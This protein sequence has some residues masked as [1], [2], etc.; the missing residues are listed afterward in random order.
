MNVDQWRKVKAAFALAVDWPSAERPQRMRA[1]FEAESFD[2]DMKAELLGLL[3]ADQG[4]TSSA[5]PLADLAP[6]M[7]RAIEKADSR[8][9]E[10][11]RGSQLGHWRLVRLIGEGGMG[12]VWLAERMEGDFQQRAA[13]KLIRGTWPGSEMQKRFRSERRILAGLQHPGIAAMLDG[14]ESELGHP[15]LAME[16]VEGETLLSWCDQRKLDLESRLELVLQVCAAVSHAHQQ[17]VVHRDLK[18]SN[19]LVDGAGRIKLLDFGIAKLIE[20]D[21][22]QTATG[23]R[24]FTPQFAAPEQ[25][26][27]EPATTS[28]DVHAL[29][30]LLYTLLTGQR[31]WG[32]TAST[33]AAYEH[34]VLRVEPVRP[35]LALVDAEH[36]TT[37]PEIAARRGLSVER[38]RARLRGD[39]DAIVMK[40]LRK[41]PEQRYQSVEALADDLHRWLQRRPV[42]ARRGNLRYQSALFAR[43]HRLAVVLVTV[44]ALSVLTGVAGTL[45]QARE[46]HRSELLAQRQAERAQAVTRLLVKTF[47]LVDPNHADVRDPSAR[48]L[49]DHGRE[50]LRNQPD[51]AD[52]V[53]A[54]M[55]IAIGGAYLGLDDEATAEAQMLE[56]LD[57][58]R[59]AGD[60][61]L[62]A[63]ARINLSVVYINSGSP[64]AALKILEEVSAGQTQGH[65]LSRRLDEAAQLNT[66]MA[67]NN[68]SR[69]GEAIDVLGPLYQTVLAREGY[70]SAAIRSMHGVYVYAL[71]GAERIELARQVAEAAGR[72]R[73]A[74]RR[75]L[76][77]SQQ[78]SIVDTLAF[79]EVSESNPVGAEALYREALDLR[80]E[81]HGEN[82]LA[83]EVAMNNV[84]LSLARQERHA[85]SVEWYARIV[86]LQ[87]LHRPPGHGRIASSMIA[88]ARAR[89][90]AGQFEA[91]R[92]LVLEG[93][94]LW[95]QGG[96]EREMSYLDGV[97]AL[98]T[99]E[100]LEGDLDVAYAHIQRL[101]DPEDLGRPGTRYDRAA[102]LAELRLASYPPG[103]AVDCEAADALVS[104]LGER[105]RLHNDALILAAHCHWQQG[106]LEKASQHL[107]D[108]ASPTRR[109]PRHAVDRHM[110][111]MRERL[112]RE[113]S[114]PPPSGVAQD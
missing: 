50:Q 89:L 7:L 54:A 27:G 37:P 8:A 11:L 109:E 80:I 107:R 57:A 40:A 83:L 36:P 108:L 113:L 38:L 67:L 13:I 23:Q 65:V 41:E 60:F 55:L 91:A 3:I 71:V 30:L 63:D 16:Y 84:A 56:A 92:R 100:E 2:D 29:G 79:I 18:P 93:M 99:L 31:P 46:A 6:A 47:Y 101:L 87:R 76:P 94:T 45:W 86:D 5:A 26:R 110:L 52:D 35:S 102:R 49:L 114:A 88:E 59:A 62:Q 68:L 32:R 53:R 77:L 72:H 20:P 103:Q 25:V 64:A 97:I 78:A 1:L 98:A 81:L 42:A 96:H 17:L 61:E 85:E 14:G 112:E 75:A 82:A 95:D 58:A 28:V 9:P 70:D 104:E 43:R 10:N 90:A 69:V 66:G 4:D 106:Q 105:S 12:S 111:E 33:P 48:M 74:S 39:L 34:A 22:E 44:I 21:A 51:L 24:L 73:H 15:W 19:I